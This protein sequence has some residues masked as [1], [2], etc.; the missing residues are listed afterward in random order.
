MRKSQ[1][2]EHILIHTGQNYDPD[3]NEVF[4]SDLDLDAPEYY[5]D[6][7]G[8]SASDTIGKI[9]IKSDKILRKIKPDGVLILGDTNSGLSAISAKN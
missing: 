4:F 3:L 6:A 7:E 9:L 1:A 8:E 5:L 2:I